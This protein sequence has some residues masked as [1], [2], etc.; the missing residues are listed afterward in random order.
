MGT[1]AINHRTKVYEEPL[2]VLL[3]MV[4]S[5]YPP[6]QRDTYK[7]IATILNRDF[8]RKC[9]ADTI[10]EYHLRCE[11]QKQDPRCPDA[12]QQAKNL[13]IIY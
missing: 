13:G 1:K 10:E 3:D 8:S 7:K 2:S 5:E 6:P 4:A 11:L 12:V 9:S